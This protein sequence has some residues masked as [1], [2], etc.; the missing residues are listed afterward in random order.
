M[1]GYE[2]DE[3]DARTG[4]KGCLRLGYCS[5]VR[6]PRCGYEEPPP[7]GSAVLGWLRRLLDAKR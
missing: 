3:K 5:M 2:Y 6:C 1:C 7:V 4:C